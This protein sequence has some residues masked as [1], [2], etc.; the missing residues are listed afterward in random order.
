MSG[1]GGASDHERA[2]REGFAHHFANPSSRANS[3]ARYP[4]RCSG[5]RANR[6]AR[7]PSWSGPR[8]RLDS[9]SVAGREREHGGRQPQ[10]KRSIERRKLR[11]RRRAACEAEELRYNPQPVRANRCNA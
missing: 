8:E 10:L 3:I 4:K 11:T 5:L 7:S 9:H 2:R 6:G 1:Y